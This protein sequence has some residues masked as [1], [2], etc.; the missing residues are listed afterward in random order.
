MLLLQKI[1]TAAALAIAMLAFSPAEAF[2]AE[3]PAN[4]SP[5]GDAPVTPDSPGDAAAPAE[6]APAEIADQ[7]NNGGRPLIERFCIDCHNAD[8]QEA[9]LDL[10]TELDAAAMAESRG[11]WEKIL[12]R[13]RFGSMPPEDAE[14]PSADQRA[15]L[16][17][18][19][20]QVIYGSGCD[21]DPKPGHVTVRRLNRAEYNNTIRDL[22]GIDLQPANEFPADEVGAGFD[23]NGDVLSLPPMLFEKYMSAA[24]EIARQVILDPEEVPRVDVERSGDLLFAIGQRKVGSFYKFYMRSDGIVWSEIDVPFDGRYRLQVHGSSGAK[25]QTVRLAMYGHDGQPLESFELGY[26]DGG[27]SKSHRFEADLTAGKHRFFVGHIDDEAEAI[28][29]L[30]IATELTDQQIA[31]ARAGVGKPLE[32]DRNFDHADIAFAIKQMSLS[33]P[34]GVPESLVPPRQSVLLAKK[35][36]KTTSAAEAARPGMRWLLRRAFR[37]PVDDQ[38]VDQYSQLVEMAYAR[39]ESFPRAMRVGVTAVLVSPR[40][41][42]RAE[43]PPADT[44]AGQ[45]VPLDNHQL[46]SR[47]SYFLWS[48]MPDETLMELADQGKLTDEQVL[49]TQVARMLD[50]PRSEA[51]A[52]NFASQWLG[53]RNL[54]TV[55]PDAK[56]FSDFSPQLLDSMREETRLVFLDVMR[57]NRSIL[58]LLDTTETYV[59]QRLA[60]FYGLSGVEGD[61][62]RRVSLGSTGRRGILTQASILTLTS[63]PT[64]TSPVKR[65]KW[66][67]ENVLGTP[68]PEPPAG[69][70][71]LEES[72]K[73]NPTASLREQLEL[74]RADPGCA[75]CHRV[76]DVL[77]FGFEKFDAIGKYRQQD[78]DF[79]IDATGELPGGLRFDGAVELI[80]ILRSNYGTQFAETT[81]QRLTTFALGRELRFEDRCV[82]EDIVQATSSDGFRFRDLVAEV[83]VSPLFRYQQPEGK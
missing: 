22:F 47:L 51:L 45:K 19:I 8:Y 27:G 81:T 38:T 3:K 50:D 40:F 42:F 24:E 48:S 16:I 58:D 78:G 20:E 30:G 41:L 32:V 60:D 49:R 13:V 37:S 39:E 23:N 4:E 66:I 31:T 29:P 68:P 5:A 54:E 80:E 6:T 62:F 67:L 53:L 21:L 1:A 10:E 63:N 25:D 18:G 7:W 52:D 9:E 46:A 35:P 74:H 28:E 56:Q 17:M 57:S 61:Q 33:G 69:V 71:Q 77:G 44:S 15:A 83:V 14:Q 75:S 76:M 43:I 70:P 59:D 64:R 79:A 12:Q 65:G 82:V 55:E 26:A 2:A 36:G 73:A 11:H 72:A 34:V